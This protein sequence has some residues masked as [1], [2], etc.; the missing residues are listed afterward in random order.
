MGV[1]DAEV[2]Y[3]HLTW[4][5]VRD[6]TFLYS[7]THSAY[8]NSPSGWCPTGF[9]Y[10]IVQGLRSASPRRKETTQMCG[11]N[12]SPYSVRP[13]LSY[14]RCFQFHGVPQR[15]VM[16][17]ALWDVIRLANM[18]FKCRQCCSLTTIAARSPVLNNPATVRI[19]T[20]IRTY[21]P[22][23]LVWESRLTF[24]YISQHRFYIS[25]IVGLLL[26]TTQL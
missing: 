23:T 4:L 17:L 26:N 20:L 5:L 2:L 11:A 25:L 3:V 8:T 1:M 16:I 10:M 14:L 6:G 19:R 9:P 24:E 13:H 21:H 18:S 22:R 15:I 7:A 12:V